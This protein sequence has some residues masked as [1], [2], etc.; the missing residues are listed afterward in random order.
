MRRLWPLPCRA[1]AVAVG[2][3][4]WPPPWR[5]GGMRAART[6]L[7][8]PRRVSTPCLHTSSLRFV[9]SESESGWRCLGS[10]YFTS[11]SSP[12]TAGTAGTAG[13]L[14]G[15]CLPAFPWT[16]RRSSLP[17]G[18]TRRP[19]ASIT[20][21][22]TLRDHTTESYA[23]RERDSGRYKRDR[24]RY[25]RP[26]SAAP[27]VCGS[28]GRL[29]LPALARFCRSCPNVA[30]TFLSAR[31]AEGRQECLPHTITLHRCG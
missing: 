1:A 30:R 19:A 9:E 23:Q 29:A 27:R 13:G 3:R 28:P 15:V 21:P 24:A 25:R 7:P 11:S 5:R 20:S 10:R 2:S 22:F 16:S 26:G 17:P 12:G 14:M 4:Q 6:V 31:V 8:A 18:R